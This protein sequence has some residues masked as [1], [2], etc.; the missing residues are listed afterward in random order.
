MRRSIMCR[1]Y[2]PPIY[3]DEQLIGQTGVVLAL[4]L[5]QAVRSEIGS[6]TSLRQAIAELDPKFR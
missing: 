6:K 1:E 5:M 3:A 4:D 2:Q